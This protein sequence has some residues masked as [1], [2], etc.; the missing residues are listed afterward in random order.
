[1]VAVWNALNSLTRC[2]ELMADRPDFYFIELIL[3][4]N[5]HGEVPQP[6]SA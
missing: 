1:M 2:A 6:A 4:L 3:Q 5:S